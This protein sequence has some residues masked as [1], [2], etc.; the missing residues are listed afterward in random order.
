MTAG[1]L[2]CTFRSASLLVAFRLLSRPGLPFVVQEFAEN[3]A[4]F[5]HFDPLHGGLM[6]PWTS[7]NVPFIKVGRHCSLLG[8]LLASC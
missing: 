3:S 7:Y 4:D 6:I 5:A 1:T 2:A 8:C